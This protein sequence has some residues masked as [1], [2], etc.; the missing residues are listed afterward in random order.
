MAEPPGIRL[1][2][3]LAMFLDAVN[4]TAARTGFSPRLV[5]KDYFCTILLAYLV[6][7]GGRDLVFKG[8]TCLAK[9]HAD[10]YRLSEDLDFAIPLPVDAAR[11]ERR[12]AA[13]RIKDAVVSIPRHLPALALDKPLCGANESTQYVGAVAYQSPATGQRESILIEVSVR[14][15]LLLPAKHGEARTLLLD[16]VTGAAA[17]QPVAARC[18]ALTEAVAEKFRAALSRRDIAIRDFYD[19]DHTVQRLGVDPRR[20]SLLE[21]V[22]RK[23]AVPG[24][25]PVDVGPG[26]LGLLQR[27]LDARLRSVLRDEDFEAFDLTRAVEIVA[28]MARRLA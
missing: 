4:F 20:T 5:E 25:P 16:P 1:H 17:V 27:Q 19:L 2:E 8:G 7:H 28:A 14:E 18:I 15:P 23:L 6:G 24:N 9:V 10:F 12:R 3:D 21:L 22:R 26:R 13:D 11:S